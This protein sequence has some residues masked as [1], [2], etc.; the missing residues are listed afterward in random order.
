MIRDIA[1]TIKP[2]N[3]G[4]SE[5]ERVLILGTSSLSVLFKIILTGELDNLVNVNS[6]RVN[7]VACRIVILH[8]HHI[9]DMK[10]NQL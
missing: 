10:R 2:R 6:N 5:N 7:L 1:Q 4:N 8:V 9:M 3:I